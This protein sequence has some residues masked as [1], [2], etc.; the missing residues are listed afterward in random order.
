LS[1]VFATIRIGCY[2]VMDPSLIRG[3]LQHRER[4]GACLKRDQTQPE[5]TCWKGTVIAPLVE[6]Q[7]FLAR[8]YEWSSFGRVYTNKRGSFLVTVTGMLSPSC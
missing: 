1:R 8:L 2:Q 7:G 6:T 4:D 5:Q 3:G